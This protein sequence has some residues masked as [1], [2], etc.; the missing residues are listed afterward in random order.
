MTSV[1]KVLRAVDF[2]DGRR[3]FMYWCPACDGAHRVCTEG[4]EPR[5]TFNGNVDRPTFGPSVKVT[6]GARGSD[7]VC[8]HFVEDGIIRYCSDSTH[9]LAGQSIDMPPHEIGA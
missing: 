9:A 2:G 8:H 4:G 3:G 5:W 1:S 6:G 7:H